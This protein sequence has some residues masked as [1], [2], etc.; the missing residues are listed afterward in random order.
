VKWGLTYDIEATLR[1]AISFKLKTAQQAVSNNHSLSSTE[2]PDLD[3]KQEEQRNPDISQTQAPRIP[4]ES[5]PR[6]VAIRRRFMFCLLRTRVLFD[7]SPKIQSRTIRHV[8]KAL[9]ADGEHN[10]ARAK[11]EKIR[12]QPPFRRPRSRQQE[13]REK[14]E[15]RGESCADGPVDQDVRA[16]V[17]VGR[18]ET[19]RRLSTRLLD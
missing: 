4:L 16:G 6:P 14:G 11:G 2:E 18:M 7:Q 1:F 3:K 17:K 13:E 5:T 9:G 10:E 8:E 12:E 19:H 15:E